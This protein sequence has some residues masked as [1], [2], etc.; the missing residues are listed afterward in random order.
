M[1]SYYIK[2]KKYKNKAIRVT[3]RNWVLDRKKPGD[4]AQLKVI[5]IITTLGIKSFK[6]QFN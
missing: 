4:I 6:G 5:L 3:I 1:Y 2:Y